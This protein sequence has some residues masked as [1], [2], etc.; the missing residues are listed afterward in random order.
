MN[1]IMYIVVILC[2]FVL[3][4][5]KYVIFKMEYKVAFPSGIKF[6]D[7][8]VILDPTD[9]TNNDIV[10]DVK[11]ITILKYFIL[12]F[13]TGIYILCIKSCVDFNILTTD[14]DRINS[15]TISIGPTLEHPFSISTLGSRSSL[16]MHLLR[17]YTMLFICIIWAR[18]L[19]LEN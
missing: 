6:G 12:I 18:F 2:H 4:A 15:N 7:C 3:F 14:F 16:T 5:N 8:R 9:E 13:D 1:C 10:P 19:N 11:S 17:L